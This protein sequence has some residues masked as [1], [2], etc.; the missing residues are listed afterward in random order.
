[1]SWI[2][3]VT[4][5]QGLR[6]VFNQNPPLLNGV[7]LHELVVD[8]EGPTLQLKLDL[9]AYPANPPAK[10]IRCGF[11]TV[12]IRLLFGGVSDLRLV[13]ISTEVVADVDI[14]AGDGVVLELR[15]PSMF[16]SASAASVTVSKL[17][18]YVDGRRE[19]VSE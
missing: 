1:M 4:N 3:L 15:S 7:S 19:V 13:G 16:V 8:R 5:P 11:N 2:D 10:W 6:E 17:E 14:K 12:Q 18:A 9:P